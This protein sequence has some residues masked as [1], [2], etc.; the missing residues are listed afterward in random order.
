MPLFIYV[1]ILFPLHLAKV[2]FSTT[3]D[4]R[5]MMNF[6]QPKKQMHKTQHKL[7][8]HRRENSLWSTATNHLTLNRIK[9]SLEDN[10]QGRVDL[11]PI[12]HTSYSGMGQYSLG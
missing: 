11:A 7:P 1:Y 8:D 12:N 2:F 4:K 10:S 3:A 6:G 5:F 9:E